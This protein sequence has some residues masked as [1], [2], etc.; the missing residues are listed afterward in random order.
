[1]H[2]KSVQVKGIMQ[3]GSGRPDPLFLATA[4]APYGDKDR[5]DLTLSA[6]HRHIFLQIDRESAMAL[7]KRILDELGVV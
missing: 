2:A 7:A 3:V 5:L 4:I 1:M 6:D